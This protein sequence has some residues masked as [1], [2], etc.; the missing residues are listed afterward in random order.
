MALNFAYPEER[1][2]AAIGTVRRERGT[3]M[4]APANHRIIEWP[5]MSEGIRS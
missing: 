2:G 5:F 4:A 3:M 1:M